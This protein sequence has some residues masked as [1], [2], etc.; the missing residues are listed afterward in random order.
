MTA[1]REVPFKK[2][3]LIALRAVLKGC[4][5]ES[6]VIRNKEIHKT[7][8][9][10]KWSAWQKKRKL[11]CFARHHLLAYGFLN[12][13]AYLEIEREREDLYLTSYGQIHPRRNI[14]LEFL[15]MIVRQHAPVYFHQ[16]SRKKLTVEDLS[17]WI[18]ESKPFFLTREELQAKLKEENRKK[19]LEAK[20]PA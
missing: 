5:T 18:R 11:G 7:E 8:D 6:C 10:A 16:Y 17:L 13:R 12:G 4:A 3:S 14:D 20:V 1:D 2:S 9:W 15:L 19:M